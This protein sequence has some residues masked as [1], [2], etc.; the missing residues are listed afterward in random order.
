VAEFL[1]QGIEVKQGIAALSASVVLPAAPW[2]TKAT[3]RILLLAVLL[4]ATPLL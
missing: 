1:F 3:V 4:M 2:P